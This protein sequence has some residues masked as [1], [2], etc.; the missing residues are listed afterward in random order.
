MAG[1]G[2][3]DRLSGPGSELRER[4]FVKVVWA[5]PVVRM[6]NKRLFQS[7]R[8]SDCRGWTTW[9]GFL[10]E[11]ILADEMILKNLGR[12]FLHFV[13]RRYPNVERWMLRG[14]GRGA[15]NLIQEE[16]ELK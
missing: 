9:Y 8:R 15:Q 1:A 7:H 5:G 14:R 10:A 3:R 11:R 6:E 4:D 13:E 2:G 16:Q 12:A